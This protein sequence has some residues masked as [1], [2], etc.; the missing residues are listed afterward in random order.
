[1]RLV[2]LTHVLV[3]HFQWPRKRRPCLAVYRVRMA[4][5]VHVWSALVDRCMDQEACCVGGSGAV[6]AYHGAVETQKYHVA[7]FQQAEVYANGFVQKASVN[8]GSRTL[9]WPDSP[10]V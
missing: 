5:G 2:E 10:S 1:M 7:C 8:S 9:M 4:D 6:A 3:Q